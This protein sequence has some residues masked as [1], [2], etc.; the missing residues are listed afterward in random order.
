MAFS[1]FCILFFLSIKLVAFW[2]AKVR[3]WLGLQPAQHDTHGKR[4]NSSPCIGLD[5]TGNLVLTE[6]AYKALV[7]A[8]STYQLGCIEI[9][10]RALFL[11]AVH[12]DLASAV[13]L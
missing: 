2:G 5:Q 13:Q 11:N 1:A 4:V 7:N 3:I 12:N 8:C 6:Y 9:L 10:F